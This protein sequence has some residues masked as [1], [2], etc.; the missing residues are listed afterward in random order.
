M[1]S[2]AALSTST[3]SQPP[4][5]SGNLQAYTGGSQ[6]GGGATAAST[7]P[8]RIALVVGVLGAV[9]AALGVLAKI[10]GLFKLCFS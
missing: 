5:G 2:Q 7:T 8:W 9:T 4:A 1:Q 6:V 3:Y 10:L